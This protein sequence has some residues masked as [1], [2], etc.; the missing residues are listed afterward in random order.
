[1]NTKDSYIADARLRRKKKDVI[2]KR[3][4]LSQVQHSVERVMRIGAGQE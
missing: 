2:M 1:M 3:S 4:F